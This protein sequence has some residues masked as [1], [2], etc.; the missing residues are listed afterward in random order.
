MAKHIPS[1]LNFKSLTTYLNK[2]YNLKADIQYSYK[3][4]KI[5]EIDK[6]ELQSKF[7]NS[8]ELENS[9][10]ISPIIKLDIFKNINYIYKYEYIIVISDIEYKGNLE[11]YA[12]DKIPELKY[13]IERIALILR[14]IKEKKKILNLKLPELTVYYSNEKKYYP[15]DYNFAPNNVNSAITNGVRIIIFRRE[16]LL[17][18]IIHELL[19]FYDFDDVIRNY[20]QEM[21]DSIIKKYGLNVSHLNVYEAFVEAF[22]NVLNILCNIT[23]AKLNTFDLKYYMIEE[24]NYSL[25][26]AANIFK[27]IKRAKMNDITPPFNDSSNTFSYYIL[28]TAILHNFNELLLLLNNSQQYKFTNIYLRCYI[29]E[30]HNIKILHEFLIKSILIVQPIINF[31][32][33]SKVK[34]I[35][36]TLRMT[37]NDK[38][39]IQKN[40]RKEKT[41]KKP[42][43]P[44]KT[45]L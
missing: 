44:K 20:P 31:N 39:Y 13:I 7:N 41:E 4:T 26:T 8:N 27:Y 34:F 11:I 25:Q 5:I 19:H 1:T 2:I 14:Y 28:K 37:I 24:I 43:K 32:I 36:N 16:E 3:N 10:F 30:T 18:S 15:T 42:K 12:N 9:H 17:K 38:F 29:D 6:F 40:K 21:Q 22:A 23:T 35:N 45:N 33:D